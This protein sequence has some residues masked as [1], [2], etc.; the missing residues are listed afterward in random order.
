MMNDEL[1][2]TVIGGVNMDVGG[3]VSG[4]LK[5]HDSNIGRISMSPGG[6]GRNIAHDLRLLGMNVRM[7]AAVGGDVFGA[8]IMGNCKRLG[9]DMSLARYMPTERSSCYLYVSDSYGEMCVAV[10][11]MDIVEHINPQ[12]LSGCIDE[13]NRS[14]AVVLDANLPEASIEFLAQNCTVPIYADTV[15]CA[16]AK[17]LLRA[18]PKLTAIKPNAQEAE[19]L[20]GE[21]DP[22]RAAKALL[23]AGVKQVFLSLGADGI[24]AAEGDTLLRVPCERTT[25]L[26]VTGAGDAITATIAWAGVCG[27]SLEESVKAATKAG[28]LTCASASR[29]SER[30]REII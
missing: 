18:L 29:N 30:L 15:S 1:F 28:A 6:V 10:N 24:I 23:D 5:P 4:V 9:I 7:I 3:H 11:D 20:T 27:L 8:T 21:S 26:D 13:I 16:K 12:Y 2:I 14:R 17:R 19:A 22:E 25:V